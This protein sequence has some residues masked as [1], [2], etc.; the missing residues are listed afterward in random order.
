MRRLALIGLGAVLLGCSSATST[1]AT[2][3][4]VALRTGSPES[5]LL[6]LD[7]L[8]LPGFT[9]ATPTAALTTADVT[10]GDQVRL[11]RL[12]ADHFEAG[13]R[14]RYFRPV[15]DF[16]NS[17]GPVDVISTV[18]RFAGIAG[19]DDAFVAEV[20][21]QDSASGATPLSTGPLGDEGH[22]DLTTA[23]ANGVTV[24]QTVLVWRTANL[25]SVLEVHE[26]L[27]GSPLTHALTIA[28]PQ[29]AR[30]GGRTPAPQ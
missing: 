3:S 21:R 6:R 15:G 5:Y 16:A 10:G 30:Q 4:Q 24:A 17:N 26:R 27:A 2:A 8:P 12:H 25:V 9:V 14:V 23:N 20:Q 19:A 1:G 28:Q 11:D 7:D 18:Q 13:A 29:V 22:G